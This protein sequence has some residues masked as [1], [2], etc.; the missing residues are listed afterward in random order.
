MTKTIRIVTPLIITL[1]I[2]MLGSLSLEMAQAQGPNFGSNWTGQYYNNSSP[3]CN[4]ISGVASYAEIV[5]EINFSWGTSSPNVNT[6]SD[7]FSATWQG[8]QN[9]ATGGTYRFTALADDGV[10]VFI[11]GTVVI[12][13]FTNNGTTVFNSA[14]VNI[15]AGTR[16]IVVQYTEFSGNAA[17]QFYWEAVDIST[18][19]PT[20][21]PTA[22]GLPP[23][24]RAH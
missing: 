4:S 11:D 15:T 19:G 2:V 16:D 5:S 22:T 18:P 9:F 13:N 14:D 12:D 10:R 20:A 8:L 7:C 3:D 1:V 24:P 17:I 21:T 6:Q 23:I